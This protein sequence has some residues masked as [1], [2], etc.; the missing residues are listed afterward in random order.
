MQKACF[1]EQSARDLFTN[2]W[3]NGISGRP[4]FHQSKRH[5]ST[6]KS[7]FGSIPEAILPVPT[8][9]RFCLSP[10]ATL[11]REQSNEADRERDVKRREKRT[12][13][14]SDVAKFAS[15]IRGSRPVPS[16]LG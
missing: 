11:R 14:G 6:E 10:S 12:A 5:W 7:L 1:L 13:A 4:S 2:Y 16:G 9:R 15:G 8:G 3:A